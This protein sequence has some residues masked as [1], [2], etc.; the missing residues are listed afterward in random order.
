MNPNTNRATSAYRQ[1]AT[2]VPPMTAVVLLYDRAIV[3][4]K[5]AVQAAQAG[6]S[7]ESYGC[8]SKASAILRGLSHVLDFDRGG[9]VAEM[10]LT[11][12]T[13]NI[14]AL[15]G[16]FGKP[17]MAQRYVKIIAGLSD[18]RDSWA[19]VAGLS[20]TEERKSDLAGPV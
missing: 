9:A 1:A 10:L 16:S 15:H 3:L 19:A 18:L 4:L 20:R 6:Q 7:E 12:Y 2:L 13:R 8:V 5:R 14:L 11:T 17:D